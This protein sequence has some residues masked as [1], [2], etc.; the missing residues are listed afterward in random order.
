M[1]Y[2]KNI[3]LPMV[4]PELH[5]IQMSGGLTSDPAMFEQFPL[6]T[7][8]ESFQAVVNTA[9]TEPRAVIDRGMAIATEGQDIV[10]A[11]FAYCAPLTI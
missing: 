2:G 5:S 9:A 11:E 4:I 3:M 6:H 7:V 1:E 8:P 10:P